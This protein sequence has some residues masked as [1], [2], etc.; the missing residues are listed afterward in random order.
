MMRMLLLVVSILVFSAVSGYFLYTRSVSTADEYQMAM[1]FRAD[2]ERSIVANGTITPR[3]Q[4]VIKPH[5]SG[6][7]KEVYVLP[8]DAVKQND[9]LALIQP[10]PDPIDVSAAQSKLREAQIR[11]KHQ[12]REL[13]RTKQLYKKRYLPRVEYE[14]AHMEWQLAKQNFAAAQRNVE[15]VRSGASTELDQSASEIRATV[16]GLVLE[17]TVEVGAFVIESNEFNV[18]TS[19]VTIAD[20]SDLIFKG[21]VDEPDAGRLE[22][23]MPTTLIVGAFPDTTFT[24]VIEFLS[25]KAL[26]KDGR[27]TFEVRSSVTLKADRFVRAGY[28]AV[29]HIIVDRREQVLAISERNL[30]FKAGRPFVPVEI[31]PEQFED[32][33]LTLGLSDGLVVEVQD[34]LREDERF[35]ILP[36]Q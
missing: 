21:Q 32:R 35:R 23:G 34:G 8:G 12:Q 30:L 14:E 9:L 18:G 20:M 13:T 36:V 27:T 2:I 29:A 6:V 7:I 28:S 3:Q 10:Y 22:R 15:I 11:L 25:P 1:P 5:I 26:V 16:S 24:G 17:R 33:V 19:I 4:V 31:H